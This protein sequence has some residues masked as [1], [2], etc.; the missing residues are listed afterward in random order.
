MKS[1]VVAQ[2]IK[3]R[4]CLPLKRGRRKYVISAQ[5]LVLLLLLVSSWL[6]KLFEWLFSHQQYTSIEF[7]ATTNLRQVKELWIRFSMKL[8]SI[9]IINANIV[10][11]IISFDFKWNIVR[12]KSVSYILGHIQLENVWILWTRILLPGSMLSKVCMLPL[13]LLS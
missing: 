2:I 13:C 3:K 11:E 6:W 9:I 1:N 10:I 4:I 5:C 12:L 8:L 7:E